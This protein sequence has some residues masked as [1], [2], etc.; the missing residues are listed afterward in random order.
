M[1]TFKVDEKSWSFR[2]A[3]LLSFKLNDYGHGV[4]DHDY[5]KDFCTYW[6]HV[7]LWSPIL[8]CFYLAAAAVGAAIGWVIIGSAFT[9]TSMFFTVLGMILTILV[10]ALTIS[11]FLHF[12]GDWIAGVLKWIWEHGPLQVLSFIF[13][14]IGAGLAYVFVKIVEL[15]LWMKGPAK[16]AK[17]TKSKAP[18]KPKQP[19]LWM[20]KY[21]A[22]K[23][24]YCPMVEYSGSEK[25]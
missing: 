5:P 25:A 2:F 8:L 14:P 23:G 12:C 16:P 1:E 10:I 21:L 4:W 3:N 18:K 6:R 20:Q 15:F 24:Q 11:A 22:L 19:S 7:L 13:T 17:P 9:A